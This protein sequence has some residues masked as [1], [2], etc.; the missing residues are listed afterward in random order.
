MPENRLVSVK[1]LLQIIEK[2]NRNSYTK[3]K[4]M[5]AYHKKF[6]LNHVWCVAVMVRMLA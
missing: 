5:Y 4:L 2:R 6:S 3:S 1:V